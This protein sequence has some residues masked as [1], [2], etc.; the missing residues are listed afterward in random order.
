MSNVT[1]KRG[2][3]AVPAEVSPRPLKPEAALNELVRLQRQQNARLK[4]LDQQADAIRRTVRQ[5]NGALVIIGLVVLAMVAAA[6]F[7]QYF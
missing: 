5:I 3:I 1:P 4:E 6:M 7:C 2:G